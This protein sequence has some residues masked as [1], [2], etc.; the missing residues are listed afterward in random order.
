[1]AEK[2]FNIIPSDTGR[3][4]SDINPNFDLP[5]L[6][7]L[8]RT[9]MDDL[10]P[11]ARDVQDKNGTWYSLRIRPYRTRANV[12][13]GVVITLVENSGGGAN[14]GHGA[15]G[16]GK[17]LK[18]PR[19]PKAKGAAANSRRR[20]PLSGDPDYEE[21]VVTQQGSSFKRPSKS[22]KSRA[23]VTP[24]PLFDTMRLSAT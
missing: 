23:I 21:Q 3:K 6:P 11:C 13:D 16:P 24:P 15:S 18:M 8:I 4:L 19:K 5:A 1:M 17:R 22:W 12:I 9:V 10:V 20:I 7:Q 14:S 2:L